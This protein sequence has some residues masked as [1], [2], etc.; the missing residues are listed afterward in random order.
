M[1]MCNSFGQSDTSGGD[2]PDALAQLDV[3]PR[4]S[5]LPVGEGSLSVVSVESISGEEGPLNQQGESD[6]LS[7]I[8]MHYS[9]MHDYQ[10]S[11]LLLPKS[12]Q[13][14]WA[15]PGCIDFPANT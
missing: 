15:F 6:S 14:I 11:K 4:H 13:E 2:A 5:A 10:Y 7:L 12:N 1:Q 3:G 8:I 9:I